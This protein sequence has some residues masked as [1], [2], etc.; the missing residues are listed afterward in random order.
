[1]SRSCRPKHSPDV[2]TE[3]KHICSDSFLLGV[4]LFLKQWQPY[5]SDFR[6]IDQ[7]KKSSATTCKSPGHS[8]IKRKR[9][10][11]KKKKACLKRSL[12]SP[13]TLSDSNTTGRWLENEAAV[14]LPLTLV[15]LWSLEQPR[16]PSRPHGVPQICDRNTRWDTLGKLLLAPCQLEKRQQVSR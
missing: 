2:S 9:K 1:M 15:P 3:L 4:K 11:K 7:K 6:C 14:G 13:R 5:Q 10:R 8:L 16:A 12:P